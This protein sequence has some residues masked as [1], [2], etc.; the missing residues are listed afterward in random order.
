MN[1][2]FDIDPAKIN[3][4]LVRITKQG[5]RKFGFRLVSNKDGKDQYGNDGFVAQSVPKEKRDTVKQGPIV[6][7]WKQWDNA[8][9]APKPAPAASTAPV[10]DDDS[11]VPF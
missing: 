5:A 8:P 9:S 6:G 7:N 4:D 2:T 3:K 11:D 10:T 1:I